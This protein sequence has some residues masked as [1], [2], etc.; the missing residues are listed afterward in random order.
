M[1]KKILKIVLFV[2]GIGALLAAI[3]G[4]FLYNFT[5][6]S[7]KLTGKQEAIPLNNNTLAPITKGEADWNSWQGPD[8]NKINSSTGILK[9]W[10]KGLKKVWEVNF[11]CQDNQTATWSAPVVSGNVLIV[12]GRDEKND[13]VFCLDALTGELRWKGQYEA[14]TKDNH[15]PGARA[16]PVIDGDRVYTYGR[17]GDLVCW[18]LQDGR[19]LWHNE[20]AK[21]GGVE[22]GWGFSSSPLV[23]GNKVIVQVG[24]KILAA[25]FDKYTGE[26]LW[27]SGSGPGGYAPL[28]LF[29]AD[30]S[31]LFL[32]G[33][34]I[35]G[36]N[37][38]TGEVNWTLP[39]MVEYNMTA[40]TPLAEGNIVFVTSGYNKGCMAVKIANNKPSV[41]WQNNAIEGQQTDPVILNGYVYG[42][43]GTGSSNKGEL[44]CLRLSDGKTMWK[45][46]EAGVGTFA[47]ADGCLV[48]LDIKGNLYLVEARPD[49][50]V[51]AGDFKKAIPDVKHPAW[52]APVI[53]NGKLY[54]RYLQSIVCYDIRS[55]STAM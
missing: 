29:T 23:T 42:Y 43:S 19:I 20:A 18:S 13:L 31:L 9:D 24:G 49:R 8:F 54:L 32:S 53:A 36:L 39:W 17:N 50:F 5:Q 35:S 45:T 34:S 52:T 11:L 46:A 55:G 26:T 6:K 1:K 44:V 28:N 3:S 22:P 14:R 40:T 30:S 21:I 33:E 51:K 38:E 7:E 47:C 25:A 41:L 27:T 16:T 12:P 37:R 15:G 10:S 48:C 4:I 2:I